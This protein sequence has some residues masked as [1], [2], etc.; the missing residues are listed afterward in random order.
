MLSLYERLGW[1]ADA[2]PQGMYGRV[3]E[4]LKLHYRVW[5]EGG[6]VLCKVVGR[7]LQ[8]NNPEQLPKVGDWV[9]LEKRDTQV[10]ILSVYPRRN[11]LS[12]KV[13]GKK[14][15][16]HILV[17]NLDRVFIVQALDDSFNLNRLERMTVLCA[18]DQIP[19]TIVLT[20]ADLCQESQAYVVQLRA[21]FACPVIVTSLLTQEGFPELKLA[22]LPQKT[23]TFIGPSGVGKSSLINMLVG[24]DAQKTRS[25][26]EADY[27]GYHTTTS[28]QLLICENEGIVID[29]PGVREAQLWDDTSA[30]LADAFE[31]ISGLS[32]GCHFRDCAHVSEKNCAV[33]DAVSQG[34]LSG[35]RYAHY[36][37]I[38]GEQR[39]LKQRKWEQKRR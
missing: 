30:G 1:G 36:I 22:V 12:R 25:V 14:T 29:T 23:H 9:S 10:R 5:H 27:K 6:E 18:Q 8:K 2:P 13:P 15:Q 35:A 3:V 33:L 17:S 26:R 37:K 11:A 16:I 4:E 38:R 39:H 31:D 20:K 32:T 19:Y 34:V 21:R 28:R 24:K 7:L